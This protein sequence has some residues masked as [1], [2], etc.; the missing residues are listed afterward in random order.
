MHIISLFRR[1]MCLSRKSGVQRLHLHFMSIISK[2]VSTVLND[3]Q[4][5]NSRY[6]YGAVYHSQRSPSFMCYIAISLG[7]ANDPLGKAGHE[8]CLHALPPPLWTGRWR[9]R[10]GHAWMDPGFVAGLLGF[11][12]G[13]AVKAI[14]LES[15]IP[16]LF[17][18]ISHPYLPP[19]VRETVGSWTGSP[20]VN[21][22][23]NGCWSFTELPPRSAVAGGGRLSRH[24]LGEL[25]MGLASPVFRYHCQVLAA[26]VS[27]CG[28]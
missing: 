25:P 7:S 14:S 4:H 10:A 11:E 19:P 17:S 28:K 13:K 27:C 12:L 26:M 3:D 1:R 15:V 24:V 8:R 16:A 18:A 22:T 9:F 2:F 5:N 20:N 6:V 21:P 23:R